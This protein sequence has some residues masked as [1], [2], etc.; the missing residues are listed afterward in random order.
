MTSRRTLIA[1]ALGS[2]PAYGLL[3]ECQP[4]RAGAD[5][6]LPAAR[7]IDRHQE[8]AQALE[9]ETITPREWQA[10]V[11]TLAA[12]IDLEQLMAEI[13]R[14]IVRP[15]PLGTGHDPEKRS[16]S[17]LDETGS[18]RRLRYAAALFQFSRH[19]V[20][21][22]HG[23]RNMVSA[24]LVVAGAF[25]VRNFDRVADEGAAII[26]RPTRDGTLR[27]GE[28]STMSA[29]RDN[30]HWFVPLTDRAV[31]FD[32]IIDGLQSGTDRFVIQAIDPVRGDKRPDGT[33]RAAVIGFVA[34]SQLYTPDV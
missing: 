32:I 12:E 29:E 14:A 23:H 4:A 6:R 13:G 25:R 17:F 11:E 3:G 30:I 26:I 22:P 27:I 18:R 20:I 34:A 19:Q 21:T 5:S 9:Q 33:I 2:F 1:T 10:R 8:L 16:V 28:V 15:A 31:T 24:H 7:W